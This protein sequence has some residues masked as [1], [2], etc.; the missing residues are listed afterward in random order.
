MESIDQV[1]PAVLALRRDDSRAQRIAAAGSAFAFSHLHWD[2]GLA[3]TRITLRT[4]A[5]RLSYTVLAPAPS[6]GYRRIDTAEDI[7]A[8]IACEDEDL[9]P[10]RG[11]DCPGRKVCGG[12][13]GGPSGGSAGARQLHAF[14]RGRDQSASAQ[15]RRHDERSGAAGYC[16]VTQDDEG[17]CEGGDKGSWKLTPEEARTQEGALQACAR[18]CDGCSYRERPSNP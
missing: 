12:A 7:A 15:G 11:W 6:E 10:C 16:E 13:S 2:A 5:T 4:L 1:I 8:L 18:K 9:C 14:E 17:D 3:Y